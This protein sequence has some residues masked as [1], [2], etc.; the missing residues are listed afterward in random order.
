[1]PPVKAT[2]GGG[3]DEDAASSGSIGTVV[4]VG[5]GG[6]DEAQQ[7][8]RWGS[9]VSKLPMLELAAKEAVDQILASIGADAKPELAIVFVTCP[10]AAEFDQVPR[11]CAC[12]RC[13]TT[14][15][16]MPKRTHASRLPPSHAPQV[17]PMLRQLVPS[18]KTIVGCT[19]SGARGFA[20]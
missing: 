18:L 4:R 16:C 20:G 15:M 12:L 14:T 13:V 7:E 8:I 10:L 1:M 19:V 5:G 11:G 9:F 2:E 17:V 6:S 3:S